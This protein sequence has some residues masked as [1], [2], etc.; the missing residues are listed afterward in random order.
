MHPDSLRRST[1]HD[2]SELVAVPR[3]LKL[4]RDLIGD[5]C[6]ALRVWILVALEL[7]RRLRELYKSLSRRAIN[8]L[9]LNCRHIY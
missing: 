9:C 3:E 1:I 5:G 7:I 8:Q 4:L 2:A 6:D